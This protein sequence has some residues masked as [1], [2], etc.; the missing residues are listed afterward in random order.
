MDK[1][2]CVIKMGHSYKEARFAFRE[3]HAPAPAA[4]AATP[5]AIPGHSEKNII[6]RMLE[7]PINVVGSIL[8]GTRKRLGATL[9]FLVANPVAKINSIISSTRTK[10]VGAMGAVGRGAGHVFYAPL[11][12][13]QLGA[14]LVAG[15]G[16]AVIFGETSHGGG[17]GSKG[18]AGAEPAHA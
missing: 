17:N 4:A 6:T 15:L 12:A 2:F 9:E 16:N 10:V 11:T 1:L 13:V 3:A 14:G 18:A 5:A 8:S 7:F